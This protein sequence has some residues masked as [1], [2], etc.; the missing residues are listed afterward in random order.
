ME[1]IR[2]LVFKEVGII[3]EY[4]VSIDFGMQLKP[5]LNFISTNVVF[6]IEEWSDVE[7]R[8]Y[9]LL[10]E[11][12]AVFETA[13]RGGEHYFEAWNGDNNIADDLSQARID[14]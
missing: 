12:A 6:F 9:L 2:P 11:V 4:R 8:H 1:E 3:I 10:N 7:T 14:A 13:P 5:R